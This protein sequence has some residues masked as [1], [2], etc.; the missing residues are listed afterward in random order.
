MEIEITGVV[1]TEYPVLTDIWEAAVGATHDF[2]SEKDIAYFRPLV[3]NDFLPAV[4]LFAARD[5]EGNIL[6]FGG[7]SADKIEMLFVDP[8]MFGNGVGKTLLKHII[9][10]EKIYK[11][12]VNEQNPSAVAFYKYMGF[13]VISRSPTDSMGKPF[14]LLH[15]EYKRYDF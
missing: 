9:R 13:E 12:D 3:L 4:K 15:L 7:T 6:G 8:L 2:L 14:P 11:L 10:E 5:S 1:E